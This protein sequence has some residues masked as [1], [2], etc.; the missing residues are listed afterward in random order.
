M[1]ENLA[2]AKANFDVLQRQLDDASV[3]V[4][5]LEKNIGYKDGQSSNSSVPFTTI[6]VGTV[7]KSYLVI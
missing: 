3:L 5:S 2:C 7:L 6:M 1:A 4:E